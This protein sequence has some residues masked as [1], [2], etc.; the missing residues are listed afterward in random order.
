MSIWSSRAT[1]QTARRREEQGPRCSS[2]D[3]TPQVRKHAFKCGA[4]ARSRV[5]PTRVYA[6]ALLRR[7]RALAATRVGRGAEQ[8]LRHCAPILAG[9]RP[10]VGKRPLRGASLCREPSQ[11][12]Y[13]ASGSPPRPASHIA[14]VAHLLIIEICSSKRSTVEIK[15]AASS[16]L[17]TVYRSLFTIPPS[18]GRPRSPRDSSKCCRSHPPRGFPRAAAP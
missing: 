6:Q 3:A 1:T 8:W 14:S 18:Q 12:R 10:A 16:L 2:G 15:R 13:I 4:V 5:A 11:Y 17:L 7:P 9:V